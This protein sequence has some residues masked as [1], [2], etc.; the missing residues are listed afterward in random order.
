MSYIKYHRVRSTIL[1]REARLVCAFNKYRQLI[2]YVWYFFSQKWGYTSSDSGQTG[3]R[4]MLLCSIL[5][6]ASFFS[7]ALIYI[8]ISPLP[9]PLPP[10]PPP[11]PP[12]PPHPVLLSVSPASLFI[13]VFLFAL[14]L[15][16]LS[17]HDELAASPKQS[18]PVM[19]WLHK[20]TKCRCYQQLTSVSFSNWIT[21]ST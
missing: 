14:K 11:P 3:T 15:N 20:I 12:T 16:L 10:P 1:Q 17:W 19:L 8:L 2:N 18:I 9:P 6:S 7:S 13:S 21:L 4:F 5:S